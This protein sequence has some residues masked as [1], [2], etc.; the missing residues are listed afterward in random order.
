MPNRSLILDANILIRA[1]LGTKASQLLLTAAGRISLF[2][3]SAAYHD[4]RHYLPK[5]LLSREIGDPESAL[6]AL[7]ELESLVIPLESALYEAWRDEALIRLGRRGPEDWPILAAA[8]AIDCPMWT[9]DRDFFGAG[10]ATWTTDR[11]GLFFR[12]LPAPEPR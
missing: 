12:N 4:A 9:E 11:V 10:V 7:D 6:V 8:L 1:I 5:I 3:P 2:A